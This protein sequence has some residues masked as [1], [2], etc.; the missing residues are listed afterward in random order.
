MHHRRKLR[1]VAVQTLFQWDAQGEQFKERIHHYLNG[2]DLS[3][4]DIEFTVK[5]IDRVLENGTQIDDLISSTTQHW[6]LQRITPIDRAILRLAVCELLFFVEQTP[7]K[8]AINEAI[9][10]GKTFGAAESPQFING[11]LDKI[12]RERTDPV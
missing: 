6:N 9:E 11:V 1:I 12:A 4:R 5:L 8:V 3:A 2:Q 10:L 7:P